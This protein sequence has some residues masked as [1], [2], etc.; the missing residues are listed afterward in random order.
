MVLC[1]SYQQLLP[2]LGC[3]AAVWSG[4][5]C[6]ATLTSAAHRESAARPVVFGR[7]GAAVRV[8]AVKL[9]AFH[10]ILCTRGVLACGL[11]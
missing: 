1:M 5:A 9:H 11:M 10:R 7:D 8:G 6:S 3:S 4:L 2:P